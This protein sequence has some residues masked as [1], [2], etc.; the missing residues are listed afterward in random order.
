MNNYPIDVDQIISW[1]RAKAALLKETGITLADIHA[2]TA[3]VPSARAD[4][5]TNSKIGRISFW[6]TGEVDFEVLR[7]SDGEFALFRHE[8]V[9][10]LQTVELDYAY[11]EFVN[12]MR[13]TTTV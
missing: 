12:A 11:D 10:S 8:S 3:N 7:R 6:A 1:F 13:S 2:N 9:P 4:F 5:D